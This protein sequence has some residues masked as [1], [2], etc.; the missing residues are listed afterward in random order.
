MSTKAFRALVL[1]YFYQGGELSVIEI[2]NQKVYIV[3]R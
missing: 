3:K 2:G 1:F